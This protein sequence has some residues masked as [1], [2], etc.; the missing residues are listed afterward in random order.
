MYDPAPFT[1]SELLEAFEAEGSLNKHLLTLYSLAVGVKA[2]VIAEIGIGRST[3]ALRLAASNT[4]GK[5][6][7][8]D[9]DEERFSYLLEKQTPNW[10]LFL[11]PSE[12]FLRTIH[13]PIDFALHDGAHDY[14][15]V[16][17]DLELLLTKMRTFGLICVHDTQQTELAGDM[18]AAITDATRGWSIS[19]TNLPFGCGLA[20]IRVEKGNHEAVAPEGKNLPNGTFDTRPVPFPASPGRYSAQDQADTSARRWLRW[21]LRKI[22]KGY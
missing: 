3:K 20:I 8:C 16:K 19:V 6:L 14:Y 21:R 5:L 4:G 7:S 22:V 13:E 17:L 1:R 10:S 12:A 15:Q 2:Q 11:G 18:L 9:A